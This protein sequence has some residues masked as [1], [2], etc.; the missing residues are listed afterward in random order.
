MDRQEA[1]ASLRLSAKRDALH[2]ED[3]EP[4]YIGI[5]RDIGGSFC[6]TEEPAKCENCF[7]FWHDDPRS[8]AEI[9]AAIERKDA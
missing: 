5:C 7:R 9:L 2:D 6:N 4:V 3:D 1:L 8:N